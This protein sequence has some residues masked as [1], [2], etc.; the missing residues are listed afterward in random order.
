MAFA[1]VSGSPNITKFNFRLQVASSAVV[2][3][4]AVKTD[5]PRRSKP[6]VTRREAAGGPLHLRIFLR[7]SVEESTQDG[8]GEKTRC[9]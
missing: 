8:T 2:Q 5:V 4:G 1:V 7:T 6:Q 3:K 9:G